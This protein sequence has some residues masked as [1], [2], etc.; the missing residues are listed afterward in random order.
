M[1]LTLSWDLFI[2]VFIALIVAYSFIIGKHES[3]KVIVAAYIAIV[4]VHGIESLV[5]RYAA[6][7]TEAF[8]NLQLTVT[9]TMIA[10]G[11]L[12]LFIVALILFSVRGGLA[13][14]YTGEPGMVTN[15]LITGALGAAKA[16]LLLSTLTTYVAGVPLL[17][18][19]TTEPLQI[20]APLLAQ[21]LL[22][23]LMLEYR[24]LWFALPAVVLLLVDLLSGSGD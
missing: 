4:A 12:L 23:Q 22:L 10:L 16:G 20:F 3:V 15:V 1:D 8:G 21:S 13:V 18:S 5:V 6:E 2:A 9:P 17:G 24:D 7:L 19:A 11:K 14:S